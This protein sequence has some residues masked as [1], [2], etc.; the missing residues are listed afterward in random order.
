MYWIVYS[1]IFGENQY[2]KRY[3]QHCYTA[4]SY[5]NGKIYNSSRL[6]KHLHTILYKN[7]VKITTKT[8]TEIFWIQ[9]SW[10]SEI[11]SNEIK[12]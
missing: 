4:V 1:A 11:S 6:L 7:Y 5:V 3:M 2:L 10:S 8:I 12:W 9:V